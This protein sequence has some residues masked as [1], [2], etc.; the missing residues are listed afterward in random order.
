MGRPFLLFTV[1]IITLT[2]FVAIFWSAIFEL[3]IAKV[4]A[5]I[6]KHMMNKKRRA[7]VTVPITTPPNDSNSE[8]DTVKLKNGDVLIASSDPNE[9]PLEYDV[10]ENRTTSVTVAEDS[11]TV[12][13]DA[14]FVAKELRKSFLA[15]APEHSDSEYENDIRF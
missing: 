12:G 3:P 10:Q 5:Y 2:Y 6:I 11:V 14:V 7:T 8:G 4:E 9:A 15:S 1:P 13:R